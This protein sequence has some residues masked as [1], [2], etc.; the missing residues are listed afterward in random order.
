MPMGFHAE[1]RPAA[2]PKQSPL[3]ADRLD[4]HRMDVPVELAGVGPLAHD[5]ATVLPQ[6]AGGV[7]GLV[8]VAPPDPHVPLVGARN[9]DGHRVPAHRYPPSAAAARRPSCALA[10]SPACTD[11]SAVGPSKRLT[12]ITGRP[13]RLAATKCRIEIIP[14]AGAYLRRSCAPPASPPESSG[15]AGRARSL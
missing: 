14:S 2:R 15:I 1:Q 4:R 8:P 9:R 5:A 11:V 13:P 10:H 6:V 7:H 12:R 3:T